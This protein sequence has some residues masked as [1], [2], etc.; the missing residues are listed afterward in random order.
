L[1]S[2]PLSVEMLPFPSFNEPFQTAVAFRAML[3][4]QSELFLRVGHR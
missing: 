3:N 1:E 4:L 2:T